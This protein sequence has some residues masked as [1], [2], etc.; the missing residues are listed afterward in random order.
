[1]KT[2]PQFII[3]ISLCLLACSIAMHGQT[4]LAASAVASADTFLVDHPAASSIDGDT[5][6]GNGWIAPALVSQYLEETNIAPIAVATASTYHT[7]NGGRPPEDAIDGITGEWTGWEASATIDNIPQWLELTWP[8]AQIVHKVVLYTN[9][10]NDG[11]WAIRGYTVQYWDGKAY[12]N[13][14]TVSDNNAEIVTSIFDT[15]ITTKIR[16][17]CTESDIS[18]S[19]YRISELEVYSN[20]R[21][22]AHHI[23]LTWSTEQ[24]LSKLILHTS[25]NP[26]HAL[27]GFDIQFW[28]GADFQTITTISDNSES[29]LISRFDSVSTTKLRIHCTEPDIESKWYRINEIELYHDPIPTIDDSSWNLD[30]KTIDHFFKSPPNEYRIIDYS[31]GFQQK[32][33]DELQSYGFGGVQTHVAYNNYLQ[34]E[35]K[36]SILVSDVNLAIENDM[37]VWIHD[38]RGYPTGAAGGLVVEGHP[39]FEN[40]GVIRITKN[41][42]GTESII[43]DLPADMQFF[44]ASLATIVDGEP[45]DENSKEITITDNQ[46]NTIGQA[47]S[48]QLSVFGV[49]ILDENTQAQSNPQFGATGHYPSL[50]SEGAMKRFIELTHQNYANHVSDISSKVELFYTNEPNLMST[51]WQYDGTQAEYAWLP[52]ESDLPNQ[53]MA[54]HGYDLIPR[55]DALFG[56]Y[57]NHSKMVR[58][59]FYQTVGEVMARNFSGQIAEWCHENGVKL[60]GHPLLEEYLICHV[61]Y[62]GDFMKVIRNYDIPAC[63]L[64]IARPD[65][66]NWKF[67]MPKFLS[68]ASY[69]ENKHGMVVAL[70]DPIIGY[71]KDDLS[72]DI[73]YL[74]RTINMSFLCGVNQLSSYIPYEEYVLEEKE[75]FLQLSHYISRISMMLRGAKNEAPIAMYYPIE[76]FQSNYIASPLNHNQITANYA[77]LQ[78]TLDRMAVDMIQNGLDFNYVTADAILNA[79]VVGNVVQ[80]G[81]H[82]YSSIV[83]PKVTVISLDVLE[84]LQSIA[85]AGIPVHWVDTAPSLG[86]SES[87][88]EAV[89]QIRSTIE[90]TVNPLPDLQLI[91]EKEFSIQVSSSANKLYMSRFTRDDQRIYYI[92]NESENEI[93]ITAESDLTDSIRLYNPVNGEIREL[94]LPLSEK[95]GRYESLFLVEMISPIF[96][97]PFTVDAGPDTILCEPVFKEYKLGNFV[98]IEGGVPPYS[99]SWSCE[100]AVQNKTYF[101]SAFLN[102]TS[103]AHPT[104]ISGFDTLNFTL[105]VRDN[106]GN[107]ASDDLEV[108]LSQF[109]YCLDECVETVYKGDSIQLSHC[110]GGGILPYTYSWDHLQSLSDPL[111]SNPWAKPDATTEYTLTLKDAVGCIAGSSCIISVLP[112]GM[113]EKE[114]LNNGIIIYPNPASTFVNIVVSDQLLGS[115]LEILDFSGRLIEEKKINWGI[116]TINI[117]SY[118]SGLY[119]I[120]I[121][122]KRPYTKLLKN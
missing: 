107:I 62:Y 25:T 40:R 39:E 86:V 61:M 67:W 101:A 17:Y 11:D 89:K 44:R 92:I 60:S 10:K 12:Q 79:S 56:G 117:S 18:S 94:S 31:S 14:D 63:D 37:E 112:A 46:I 119:F 106:I 8:S 54:M 104:F 55:L 43:M 95:I 38:E 47:G 105:K 32:T 23:D 78:N 50:L 73:P 77:Y 59:H 16:I 82:L 64:P 111:V 100:Y 19:F 93:T 108:I 9:P 76:S 28:N 109:V 99:Y 30:F 5:T 110:I 84:K 102:D 41:G 121:P 24:I 20:V 120:G 114:I 70:I 72:P 7:A 91:R 42:S 113:G 3:A 122:G 96:N 83:M 45:D 74:K 103:L 26:N 116:C 48:W 66:T 49:K 27:R 75:A 1:M 36:W 34:D 29:Q 51:Y 87:E 15:V 115:T 71:G 90:T 69:L 2:K 52:W 57:S 35:S 58:L 6:D 53:F 81:M 13:L 118:L 4:N 97:S 21:I 88:H 85:D 33:V 65:K 80:I 22:N 98:T 68:S